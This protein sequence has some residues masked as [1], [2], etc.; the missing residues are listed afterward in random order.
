MQSKSKNSDA[1][2]VDSQNTGF[3]VVGK[4]LVNLRAFI[5]L[6]LLIGFF[7]AV[8]DSFLAPGNLVI[9][10]KQVAINAILGIGMTFVILTGGIDL[11]VGSIVGLAGM[12]AGA[13]INE[14]S[15]PADVWHCSLFQCMDYFRNYANRRHDSRTRERHYHH[16]L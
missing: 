4:I 12:V 14:G 8:N 16:A 13:L 3:I 15:H 6:F 1:S 10:T 11:S 2:A 9:L 5:A 7:A